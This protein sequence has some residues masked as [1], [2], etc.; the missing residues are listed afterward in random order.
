MKRLL[1]CLVAIV[2]ITLTV[3]PVFA[4][5]QQSLSFT[6]EEI[7]KI[8]NALKAAYEV[9]DVEIINDFIKEEKEIKLKLD[10][11]YI[12]SRFGNFAAVKE[13]IEAGGNVNFSIVHRTFLSDAIEKN[14]FE[15]VKYL[16]E[17]GAYVNVRFDRGMTIL[18]M[19]LTFAA[20]YE[21]FEILD[22]L[23]SKG[24]KFL[25]DLK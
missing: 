4:A 11:I 12:E 7:D 23:R 10:N 5:V 22:Y 25:K 9:R 18:S 8:N 16:V 20:K 2:F 21:S 13:Y 6:P 14:N 24:A 1:F 3:T 17:N 15:A 19:T